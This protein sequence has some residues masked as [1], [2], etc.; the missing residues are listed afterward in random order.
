MMKELIERHI[1]VILRDVQTDPRFDPPFEVNADLIHDLR[2][3][4]IY[5][6]DCTE[7]QEFLSALQEIVVEPRVP[8]EG[9]LISQ[10]WLRSQIFW[11]YE[12][13]RQDA[14]N[15]Y[16]WV[17]RSLGTDI[18][19]LMES[20]GEDEKRWLRT[21]IR[22]VLAQHFVASRRNRNALKQAHE[23]AEKRKAEWNSHKDEN[24][25]D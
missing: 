12:K 25:L 24:P 15:L 7:T 14:T 16:Q 6:K 20:L 18:N 3:V 17:S 10:N 21:R 13:E 19:A 4:G 2:S 8:I 22:E 9:L 5:L 1:P 23:E 11:D